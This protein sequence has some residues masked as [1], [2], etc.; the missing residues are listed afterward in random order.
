MKKIL[1]TGKN[2]YIGKYFKEWGEKKIDDEMKIDAVG[3]R[4]GEWLKVNF[5]E[6]DTVLHVAGI[7][8]ESERKNRKELYYEINRDLAYEVA[9]KAKNSGVKHFIFFS[10]M[11]VYGLSRGEI[12]E[13]TLPNP[14]TNYGKSKLEAEKLINTLKTDRFLVTIIRPPLV[15]GYGCK[16]NYQKLSKYVDKFIIFPQIQ[17]SR[18]MIYIENLCFHLR[19]LIIE[20]TEGIYFPQNNEYVCTSE[21]VKEIAKIKNK[22]IYFFNKLNFIMNFLVKFE[23]PFQKVFG[24]LTYSEALSKRKNDYNIV[25]FKESIKLTE[26]NEK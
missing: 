6:Y 24:S 4:N 12:T 26:R 25:D 11:S 8:H 1:I 15:Y 9:K 21:L 23:G 20:E 17:N 2:S 22:R 10:T 5:N 14:K 16:G 3:M 18:S 7:A 19:K 13:N